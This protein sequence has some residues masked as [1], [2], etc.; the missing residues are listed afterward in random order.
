MES[1]SEEQDIV[2]ES[3]IH[4]L[5]P[6]YLQ[7]PKV[8]IIMLPNVLLHFLNKLMSRSEEE[9]KGPIQSKII[10]LRLGKMQKTKF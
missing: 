9:N 1:T 8:T 4:I 5:V 7:C 6:A 3:H 10:N 2:L